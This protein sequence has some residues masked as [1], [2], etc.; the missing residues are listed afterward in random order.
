MLTKHGERYYMFAMKWYAIKNRVN[1]TTYHSHANNICDVS[2]HANP[3]KLQ[4]K[5]EMEAPNEM[6]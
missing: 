5:D 2:R 4:C 6:R 1:L 3:I